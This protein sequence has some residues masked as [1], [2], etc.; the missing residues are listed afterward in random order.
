MPHKPKDVARNVSFVIELIHGSVD[1]LEA[2]GWDDL[3]G[4]FE[5]LVDRLFLFVRP[6]AEHE[7]DLRSARVLVSYTKAYACVVLCAENGLDVT[8]SVMPAVGALFADPDRTERQVEVIHENEHV[9]DGDFLGLQP[10]AYGVTAEVHVGGRF[11]Q[12]EFGILNTTFRHEPVPLI[13]PLGVFRCRK[14]IDH[15]KT[16][17]MTRTCVLVTDI[18]KADD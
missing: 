3:G 9:L 16:D 14:S 5:A 2:E 11:K 10:I 18:A 6:F 7:V 12:Y 8:E 15:H 17:I 4:H 13:F 1:A